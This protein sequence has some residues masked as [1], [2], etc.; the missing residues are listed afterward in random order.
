MTVFLHLAIKDLQ[1]GCCF[2]NHKNLL[3]WVDGRTVQFLLIIHSSYCQV[4]FPEVTLTFQA[5]SQ[6]KGQEV[7][8]S[9]LVLLNL[10]GAA[11]ILA[12]IP[13][14]RPGTRDT[15]SC[16]GSWKMQPL[17]WAAICPAQK[18]IMMKNRN[19]TMVNNQESYIWEQS[20]VIMRFLQQN[21]LPF[22]NL[23]HSTRQF[24]FKV[25]SL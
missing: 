10:P 12:Y 23:F 13:L 25:E 18:S 24:Y 11:K 6:T 4:R 3:L 7:C 16:K 2:L 14:I 20:Q 15:H 21:N 9:Y 1:N 22:Q 5:E 19:N 17:F 8:T